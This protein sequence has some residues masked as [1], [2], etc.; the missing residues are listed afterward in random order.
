M[1]I[2][3]QSEGEVTL[4]SAD[5]ADAPVSDPKLLSHPYDKRV[6]IETMKSMMDYLEA[7]VFKKNTVKMIGCPKSRSDEDIW[8]SA[9]RRVK[10]RS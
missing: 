5:P 4:N 3:P 2:D 9:F 8:V 7:P 10:T 6:M 1:T